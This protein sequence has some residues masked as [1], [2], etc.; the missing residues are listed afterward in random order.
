M[1][2]RTKKHRKSYGRR[3]HFHG[4]AKKWRGAGNRGGRGMAGTGKRADQKKPSVFKEFGTK[5]F[6]RFGFVVPNKKD[7][8][9]INI[10]EIER[11]D[12]KEINLTEMGYDKLLGKGEL[13][14]KVIITVN[15]ASEKAI[16][17]VEKH[18]GKVI[19]PEKIITEE[20]V[21]E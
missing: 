2:N 7:I 3:T 19:L 6:G 13:T 20:P 5:Y 8:T 14:K 4:A 16:Q 18:G 15:L 12:K 17:K 9:F 10:S 1:I 11:M 21:E